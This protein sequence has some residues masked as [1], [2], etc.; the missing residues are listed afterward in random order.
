[1]ADYNWT[2]VLMREIP[3]NLIEG[4]ALHSYSFVEWNK[5]G[6]ATDFDEA[7]YFSTMQTELRMDDLIRKHTEI[8]DKYDPKQFLS[9]GRQRRFPEERSD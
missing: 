4:V 7:Q 2:E 1:M 8:M 5:K 6:S 9:S 3:N